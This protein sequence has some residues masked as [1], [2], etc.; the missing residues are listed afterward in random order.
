MPIIIV[1]K[2]ELGAVGQALMAINAAK[3]QKLKIACIVLNEIEPNQLS[4]AKAL[5]GYTKTRIVE[6]SKTK[7]E[8][9]YSEIEKLI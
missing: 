1:V 3:S 2:D 7:L 9:F 8:P 4:N 6:Y 5:R